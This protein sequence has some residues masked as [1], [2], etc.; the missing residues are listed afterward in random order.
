MV[1]KCHVVWI[2][3]FVVRGPPNRLDGSIPGDSCLTTRTSPP[4]PWMAAPRM[5]RDPATISGTFTPSPPRSERSCG[6]SLVAA[7]RRRH[8]RRTR[9]HRRGGPS[10]SSSFP[11]GIDVDHLLLGDGWKLEP[12]QSAVTRGSQRRI[13]LG[14]YSPDV[15]DGSH[16]AMGKDC[17]ALFP[18]LSPAPA[19]G[20]RPGRPASA[21][22]I[23]PRAGRRR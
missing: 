13:L 21:T 7:I 22:P 14:S 17:V 9:G 3:S 1:V 6:G 12:A 4:T 10:W 19:E 11:S 16:S 5:A 2:I 20:S 15:D 18:P 23:R 8:R